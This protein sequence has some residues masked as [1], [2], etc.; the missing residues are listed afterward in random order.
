MGEANVYADNDMTHSCNF[1]DYLY[2]F[3]I[4][5]NFFESRTY[6]S[7][8]KEKRIKCNI[9]SGVFLS[10]SD[11]HKVKA[12]WPLVKKLFGVTSLIRFFTPTKSFHFIAFLAKKSFE[13]M[14]K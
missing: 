10:F 2:F 11:N 3:D 5:C 6:S 8:H 1:F 12:I 14:L 4:F 9:V 13:V 7:K